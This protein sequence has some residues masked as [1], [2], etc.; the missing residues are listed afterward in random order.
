MR[1]IIKELYK[2]KIFVKNFIESG[3]VEKNN[4]TVKNIY[5]ILKQNNVLFENVNKNIVQRLLTFK[6]HVNTNYQKDHLINDNLIYENFNQNSFHDFSDKQ[7]KKNNVPINFSD[8]QNL[9]Q[10]MTKEN[11]NNDFNNK[12]KK[13]INSENSSPSLNSNSNSKKTAKDSIKTGS[14]E[15]KSK[16]DNLNNITISETSRRDKNKKKESDFINQKELFEKELYFLLEERKA[17]IGEESQIINCNDALFSF[18]NANEE[19]MQDCFSCL[20][21]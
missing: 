8:L 18:L 13:E 2:D 3:I 7:I 1:N 6:K 16:Y 20:S 9:N 5:R 12:L 15:E 19:A 14:S 17:K 11:N 4:I 21:L 10:K